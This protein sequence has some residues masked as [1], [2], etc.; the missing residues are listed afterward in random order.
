M[1]VDQLGTGDANT[2]AR[3]AYLQPAQPDAERPVEKT[4]SGAPNG[5]AACSNAFNLDAQWREDDC[6][7]ERGEDPWSAEGVGVEARTA[8]WRLRTDHRF[9]SRGPE[10]N[11]WEEACEQKRDGP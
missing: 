2:G 1:R 8:R 7:L 9:R 4:P 6:S 3:L 11:L 10:S 5:D